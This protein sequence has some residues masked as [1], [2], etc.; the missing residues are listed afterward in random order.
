MDWCTD[1]GRPDPDREPPRRAEEGKSRQG[2]E[3]EF[4]SA[5]RE[6]DGKCYDERELDPRQQ[7]DACIIN[8]ASP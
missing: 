1:A 5:R 4:D 8:P 2:S 3:C 7:D 6:D